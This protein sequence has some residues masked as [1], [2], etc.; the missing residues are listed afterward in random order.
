[1]QSSVSEGAERLTAQAVQRAT[2]MGYGVRRGARLLLTVGVLVTVAAL[3]AIASGFAPSALA[4]PAQFGEEG[5]GP[6][7]FL[8][9]EV[10]AD[11]IAVNQETRDVYLVDTADNRVVQFTAEGH[12]V[13]AWGFG[14]SD[15]TSEA[16]Q[17]CE[18]QTLCFAGKGGAAG[19]QLALP[20]GI[21]VDNSA[22]LTHGDVYV[23]DTNNQ[24]IERFGPDGEF[25]LAI[26]AEVSGRNGIAV[27]PDGTVY[28]AGIS[29]VQ[30]FAPS[31]TP[32][33][34]IPLP[35]TG[36]VFGLQVDSSGDL[37]VLRELQV[38]VSK[39]DGAGVELGE[40]RD[41]GV[42]GIGPRLR[43]ARAMS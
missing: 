1:M 37:Y 10:E 22:G 5:D 17:V 26:G 28:V 33:G 24:R 36:T 39:Y 20:N 13:R 3:A 41:P 25:I 6:G 7:Q 23:Q 2:G 27:G 16:F 38:G 35:E 30:K 31:G 18:S 4:L 15:G 40:V 9:G 11:G 29:R 14:V 8:G 42:G 32:E 21:A 43:L 12:F 34:E 19:G